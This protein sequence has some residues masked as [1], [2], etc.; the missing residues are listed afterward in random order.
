MLI[1]T[2]SQRMTFLPPKALNAVD[3]ITSDNPDCSS[4]SRSP[5]E[6]CY[7]SKKRDPYILL[8]STLPDKCG[9]FD[10]S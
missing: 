2:L 10:Y 5:V 8:M 7:K 1:L 6:S 9:S 3:S 4:Q